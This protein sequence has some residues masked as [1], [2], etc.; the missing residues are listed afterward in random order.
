M[1]D[2][3][4]KFNDM[5]GKNKADLDAIRKGT[6]E[7]EKSLGGWAKASYDIHQTQK[8]INHIIDERK[9]AEQEFIKWT[10]KL[11]D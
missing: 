10:I 4:D 11:V 9:K 8:D 2:S 3:F 7:V 6:K 5:F 1:A